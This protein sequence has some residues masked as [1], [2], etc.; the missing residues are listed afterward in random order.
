VL[1]SLGKENQNLNK[2]LKD[3]PFNNYIEFLTFLKNA[4]SG[5][6]GNLWIKYISLIPTPQYLKDELLNNSKI[7]K[8]PL[9]D[10]SASIVTETNANDEENKLV[11]YLS[12]ASVNNGAYSPFTIPFTQ[13]YP[14]INEDWNKIYLQDGKSNFST[15]KVLDTSKT[16]IA[17]ANDFL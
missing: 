8:E 2:I 15:N 7:L 11:D 3:S 6:V 12:S 4:S 16:N 1:I 13:T 17:K 14:F 9:P 10:V 5:G